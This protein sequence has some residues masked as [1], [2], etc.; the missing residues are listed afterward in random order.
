MNAAPVVI[1]LPK[2]A[3]YE[4]AAQ[5]LRDAGIDVPEDT[6]RRLTLLT[7]DG[8]AELL[9]LRPTDV[10]AYVEFGAADCGIVGKDVLWE[11]ERQVAE[12]ADL[13]FGACRLVVAARRQDGYHEGARYPTFL[14]VATKFKRSAQ[15]YFAERDL[16]CEIIGLHGSV[17]LAPLVGLSDVIVDLVATGNTLR[18]HDMVVVDEIARSTARFVVNPVRF[19]AKYEPAAAVR[20]TPSKRDDGMTLQIRQAGDLDALAP[21]YKSGWDAPADVREGVAQILAAVSDRGD[22]A[23]LEY[24]RAFDDPAFAIDA[25]AVPIPD[26]ARSAAELPEEIVRALT[27]A[28]GRVRDFHARQIPP[29]LAYRDTDGTSYAFVSRPLGAIAAYVP[30]GTAVLPSSVIMNTVPAKV[31]GVDRVIVLSP[32]RREGGVSPAILFACALCG[33]D[34]LYAVGGAQAIGAAA[35]GTRSIAPVDKIVGPGNVW[36]TEAKRQVFG[37]C[38]IDGLAGPS[39]VLVVADDCADPELVVCGLLAQAEHDALARVAVVSESRELLSHALQHS[40]RREPRVAD[41]PDPGA[42]SAR[43]RVC[44]SC[45]QF[46]ASV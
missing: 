33:V 34:G 31:A 11:T 22:E 37:I 27:I 19:R 42:G 15:Q 6:G 36:V 25:L 29:D 26:A 21:L 20:R 5:R 14:R 3:L 17:E 8:R 7:R 24:T 2:G 13:E 39:E 18:E 35:F 28:H 9:F 16:P 30:G 43:R 45:R 10:P 44:D 41:V 32:P 38:G 12:L 23:V 40:C 1:A 4:P 46:R